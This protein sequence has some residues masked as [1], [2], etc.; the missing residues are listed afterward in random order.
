MY[1]GSRL[2]TIMCRW[3]GGLRL[4]GLGRGGPY[5]W[6]EAM[7]TDRMMSACRKEQKLCAFEER[8]NLEQCVFYL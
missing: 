5:E 6:T 7:A 2:E 1:A 4:N 3:G 8:W